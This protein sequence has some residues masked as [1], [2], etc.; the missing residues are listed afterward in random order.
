MSFTD[1]GDQD[2]GSRRPR[3]ADRKTPEP[4]SLFDLAKVPPPAPM[5]IKSPTSIATASEIKDKTLSER[6]K[7]VEKIVREAGPRGIAR[8]AIAK[9]LGVK[10]H[11]I[12]SSVKALVDMGRIEELPNSSVRNPESNRPAAL[13]VWI[14]KA[15]ESRAIEPAEAAQHDSGWRGAA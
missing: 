5:Q 1:P 12:S 6:R 3:R 8:F 15:G 4:M 7:A 2:R 10:D 13:L 14:E 9:K 11:W